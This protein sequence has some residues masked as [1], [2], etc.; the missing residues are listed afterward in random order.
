MDEEAFDRS[1]PVNRLSPWIWA[2]V[3]VAVVASWQWA[4]V[5]ANYQGNWTALFCT[6]ALQ[7]HPSLVASEHVYLFPDSEGYDGQFYHYIAHDPFMLSDL[8]SYVDDPSLRYSRILVPLAAYL[9]ATGHSEWIDRSY[10]IIFLLSIALGTYMSSVY[11]QKAGLNSAWGLFF[12]R[13]PPL[14]LWTASRGHS[15]LDVH[16]RARII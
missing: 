8:K 7:R 15:H 3:A 9:L 6:G 13:C 1:E 10:E 14:Q 2:A 4:T 5:Y 12:G 16:S 11:A